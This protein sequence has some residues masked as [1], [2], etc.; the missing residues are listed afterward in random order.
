MLRSLLLLGACCAFAPPRA[1]PRRPPRALAA[2]AMI[3]LE[4]RGDLDVLDEAAMLDAA[5]FAIAPAELVARTREFIAGRYG[6]DDGGASLDAAFEFVGPFVGP[7]N[8][9]QY[10]EALTGALNPG[11]GFSDL[12]GR[13]YGFVVDPIEPGR[14]WWVTRPTGTFDAP[15]FG[16]EP[17]GRTLE[18]PPQAMGVVWAP[19]GRVRKLNVGTPMDR[20]AGNTGGLG[21]LFGF[22]WFV[23]KPLPIRE[24]QPYRKSLAFE[25]LNAVG[26]LLSRAAKLGGGCG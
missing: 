24:C 11:D 5:A 20:T 2:A 25:L 4:R 21:G 26:S 12:R 9:E 18:T 15:W 8:R 14:V 23:G 13:Q 1:A 6:A 17:T 3:E 19:S 16:A 7:L 22:L 10:I